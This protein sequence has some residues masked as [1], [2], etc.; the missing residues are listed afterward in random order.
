MKEMLVD[1]TKRQSMS[2]IGKPQNPK[3]RAQAQECSADRLI[4]SLVSASDLG[5][6]FGIEVVVR[7]ELEF[8]CYKLIQIFE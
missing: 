7:L 2:L 3:K 4:K 6:L 1:T 8:I 5:V